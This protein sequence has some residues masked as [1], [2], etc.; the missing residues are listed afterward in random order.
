M[1]WFVIGLV[2]LLVA[3][4]V[5]VGVLDH[6]G[7]LNTGAMVLGG[8]KHVR[9][10]QPYLRAYELGLARS[11]A[12]E[13]ERTKLEDTRQALDLKAKEL[14]KATRELE[15]RRRAGK[16]ELAQ[17][18]TKRNELLKVVKGAEQRDRM[19]KVCAAMPP[20]EAAKVLAGLPDADLAQVLLRLPEKQAGAILSALEAR[21][22]ARVLALLVRQ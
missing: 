3:T 17:L 16:D 13:R 5:V 18:E 4:G 8:L 15:E 9:S 6:F 1:R 11:K 14:E 12:L 21:R 7:F 10:F 20:A 2:A 22:A 19:A